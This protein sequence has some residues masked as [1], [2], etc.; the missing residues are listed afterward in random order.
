MGLDADT[1]ETAALLGRACLALGRQEEAHQLCS[2]SE[3]LAGHALKASIAWRTLRAHL[4]TRG[5]DHDAARA[6]AEEAV[7]L[8]ERTDALVDHGDACLTLA[9]VLVAAGDIPGARTAV[10]RAIDLYERKGAAALAEIARDIL[11]EQIKPPHRCNPRLRALR[12]AARFVSRTKIRILAAGQHG[13]ARLPTLLVV[14][15]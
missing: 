1:A 13:N 4:L 7:T 11:G 15:R 10:G 6:V 3:Q 9:T 12:R 5:G 8:A 14:F 2:E